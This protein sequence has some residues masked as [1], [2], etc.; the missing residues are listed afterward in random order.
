MKN[1]T[2]IKIFGVSIIELKQIQDS[3]GSIMH[4]LRAD[5][6]DFTHFGECY[7]SEIYPGAVKAWKR[8]IKQTQIFAVPVGR[9]ILV[10]FDNRQFS[11]TIGKIIEVTL[12]RPDAFNRVTVPPGVW[13]GFKCISKDIALISNCTDIPHIQSECQTLMFNDSLIPYN[14]ITE[15]IIIK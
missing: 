13:Y 3:R 8:H 5:E 10:I 11:K 12:G 14:W 1:P 15:E 4:M 6:P 7:F 9:V 2:N